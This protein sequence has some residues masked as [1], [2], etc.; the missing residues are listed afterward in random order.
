MLKHILVVSDS[1]QVSVYSQPNIHVIN[2][3]QNRKFQNDVLQHT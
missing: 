3:I 2:V 1:V